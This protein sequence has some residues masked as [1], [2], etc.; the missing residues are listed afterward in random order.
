MAALLDYW[1]SIL[2]VASAAVALT[3]GL[4]NFWPTVRPWPTVAEMRAIEQKIA[5]EAGKLTGLVQA[6]DKRQDALEIT[7]IKGQRQDVQGRLLAAER[8]GGAKTAAEEEYI[9]ELKTTMREL[10]DRLRR[11][12]SKP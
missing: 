5:H 10:R 9:A 2:T 6:A 1:K 11:L 7:I 8:R 3:V 12:E 4:Y